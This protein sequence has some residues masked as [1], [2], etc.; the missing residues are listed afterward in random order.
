MVQIGNHH[1]AQVD[2]NMIRHMVLNSLR[3]NRKKYHEKYGEFVICADDTN[4]WRRSFFPYYKAS[5]KKA[6]KESELDWN[7]IFTA[8]NNVREELKTFFPYKVIQIPTAEAD[9]VIGTIVHTE[10]TVLNTGKPILI[11]SGDKD[12][13]QLHKYANVDQW[14]PTRKR[15]IKHSDPDRYLYE[16]IIKGDVGDG[17][18]NVL[19]PDNCLVVGER[20]KPVTKKRLDLFE[21]INN[22]DETLKRNW[23]RNKK[24]IDLSEVPVS[25][26]EQILDVYGEENDKDRS[27]LFNYFIKNKLKFLMESIQDF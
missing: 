25:I 20:Q 5:R 24:L 17:V 21:D 11:L 1:N 13:I 10:G 14:D 26:K 7:A 16:H 6:R 15:W 3:F 23:A 18:P 8:L 2:E 4:Y 12:Y 27:Q 9:D 19:S 22:L